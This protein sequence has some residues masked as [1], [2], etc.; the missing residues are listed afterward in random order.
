MNCWNCG[1]SGHLAR[2]CARAPRGENRRLPAGTTITTIIH[3]DGTVCQEVAAAAAPSS[4]NARRNQGRAERR[5][6]QRQGVQRRQQQQQEEEEEEEEEEE[7]E[8]GEDGLR[9]ETRCQTI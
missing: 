6:R 5:R 1:T 8:G 4:A 2:D 3:P 9:R 7:Q